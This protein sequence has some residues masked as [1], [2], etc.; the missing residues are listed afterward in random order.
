MSVFTS[1]AAAVAVLAFVLP[2]CEPGSGAGT[3]AGDGDVDGDADGDGDADAD[4]DGDGDGDSDTFCDEQDFAI[5]YQPARL[6]ILLDNSGSMKSKT[7]LF[8]PTKWEQA[9]TAIIG[10][11]QG[12]QGSG[13]FEF[14]FD[15]F[16]DF[17]CQG[18]CC[19]VSHPVVADC[20]P[21][22]E[23]E[24]IS[25]VGAAPEPLGEFDTPLCD[26]MDR[27][28]DPSY[29]PAFTGGDGPR[30]LVVVSDGKEECNGGGYSTM[31]GGAPGYPGAVQIV[32]E[33]LAGGVRT[34]V[35]G[36][37][38]G[39]DPAQLNVIAGNGGTDFGQYFVA[40]G[41]EQLQ[42]AFET[43]ATAAVSCEFALDEPEASADPDNVNFYFDEEVVPH[44][45]GCQQGSGWDWLD[46]EHTQVVFCE[47]ACAELQ[48]GG[49]EVVSAKFGCPTVE[50]E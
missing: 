9:K 10:L 42:A 5:V 2:A 35:I 47:A 32:Q 38:S 36:F 31:C 6:M 34:F 15:V 29:A 18:F 16:P 26:G 25:F 1:G 24:L 11:L 20:A 21:D 3:S 30:Y 27:F 7:G 8:D 43:I 41:Q 19:D 12:F 22:A 49:V 48:S 23:G 33:L 39:V 46:A 13:S 37:G 44:D 4:G 17:Q 14:G 40:S 45:E 28:N 50:V